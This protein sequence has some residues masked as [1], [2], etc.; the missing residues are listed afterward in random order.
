VAGKTGTAQI[1]EE[2]GYNDELTITS[3]VGF[4]PAADP[5]LVVLI[6]LSEPKTSRWAE[7][8]ALPVFGQVAQDAINVLKLQPDDR[9]P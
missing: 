4:F 9:M 1:P 7:Q 6:K 3:F 8:V 2:G 5:Q